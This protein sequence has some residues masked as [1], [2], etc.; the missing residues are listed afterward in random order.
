VTYKFAC[1]F[2]KPVFNPQDWI[3]AETS[4][5]G[6]ELLFANP[7]EPKG[8]TPETMLAVPGASKY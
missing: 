3:I 1:L 7:G 6:V 5:G 2:K 8:A 4:P